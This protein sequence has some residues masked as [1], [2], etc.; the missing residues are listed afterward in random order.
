MQ[1]WN[2]FLKYMQHWNI[3]ETL[4]K[5]QNSLLKHPKNP[6]ARSQNASAM[7][8]PSSR[9]SRS[10][11][12]HLLGADPHA[13]AMQDLD[14]LE[15]GLDSSVAAAPDAGPWGLWAVAPLLLCGGRR[16]FLS[17]S[18]SEQAADLQPSCRLSTRERE[19]ERWFREVGIRGLVE[20]NCEWT[21]LRQVFH[22]GKGCPFGLSMHSITVIFT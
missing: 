14:E 22:P 19:R 9:R 8:P 10:A 4:R 16:K 3:L 11:S 15:R 1:H 12:A 2:I 18:S 5:S 21:R 20:H 17:S 6:F 7:A 13:S